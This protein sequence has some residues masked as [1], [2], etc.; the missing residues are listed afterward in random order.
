MPPFIHLFLSI[1]VW[2]LI[3]LTF[4]LL[5]FAQRRGSV[6]VAVI[7]PA[8]AVAFHTLDTGRPL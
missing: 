8:M 2:T 1:T 6:A 4:V 3:V 5:F 7:C